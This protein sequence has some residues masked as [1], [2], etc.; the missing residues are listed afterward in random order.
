MPHISV[1]VPVYNA[2]KTLS[3]CLQALLVQTVPP[4]E[5]EIIAVDD[6]SQDSSRE[7]LRRFQKLGVRV[8][9]S[10]HRG[11]A[12]ARNSGLLLA[13]GEIVLFTDS[14]CIPEPDWA[15]RMVI[16][17]LVAVRE[18]AINNIRIAGAKG[19]YTSQ[20]KEIVARFAQLEYQE[21]YRRL[22][23]EP[24]LEFVDT[25][26]AAYFREVLVQSSGFNP[27]FPGAVV[28]DAEL[29]WRLAEQGY[30]M[31]FVPEARVRHY[32]VNTPGAYFR[33]KFRIGFWRVAVYR[34][35]PDR[36]TNDSH[37]SDTSKIQMLLLVAGLGT[38][39]GGISTGLIGLEKI[40]KWFSLSGSAI[41]GLFILSGLPFAL[42]NLKQDPVAAIFSLPLL[43]LKALALVTG[44]AYGFYSI[45]IKPHPA[46]FNKPLP[47]IR[48]TNPEKG[49]VGEVYP[50]GLAFRNNGHF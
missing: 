27:N 17:L 38:K 25:Y 30:R 9:Y 48:S 3:E 21:R 50:T 33:R 7:I 19:T 45:Y 22:A 18:G 36:L 11:A 20:Q 23:R 14:D 12:S 2:E 1:I 41:A 32:H 34:L 24:Y 13:R 42:R 47:D 6:G 31:V 49:Y 10:E 46:G 15:L 26:A 37:T 5:L 28:E 8:L 16:G 35:H 43:A 4:L 40:S 44:A 29:A 39:L